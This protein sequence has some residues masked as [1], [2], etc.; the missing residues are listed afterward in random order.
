MAVD[1]SRP[2][3]L[4]P[5][6]PTLLQD[7][8]PRDPT[9]DWRIF[10]DATCAGLAVLIPLP[11]VDMLFEAVFRRRIPG[12]IASTRGRELAPDVRRKLGRARQ[13]PVSLLGCL[14]V[15]FVAVRYVLRRIWRKI[16][17]ILAVKDAAAA[18][19]SYWH[20]AHL[21]DHMLL[22]GHLEPGVDTELAVATFRQTLGESDPSPLMGL[23]RQIAANAHH[24]L[25]LM[26]QARRLGAEQATR[27]LGRILG[28]HWR[29]AEASLG[30][31]AQRYNRNY[32]LALERRESAVAAA[33]SG[34]V[35]GEPPP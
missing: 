11:L 9:F 35:P 20:R 25:L 12:T 28:S 32:R 17:Y 13:R 33:A 7:R 4:A 24:V 10:A 31:T 21:I 8:E 5:L 6:D 29:Q 1:G 15:V 2:P 3:A 34:P 22:A 30:E 27:S 19:S 18:V 14:A 16:I 26:L 23:A